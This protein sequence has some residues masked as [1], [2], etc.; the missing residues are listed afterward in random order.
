MHQTNGASLYCLDAAEGGRVWRHSISGD[1]VHVEGS[2]TLID[3]KA[4]VGGGHAGVL[5]F[6]I[7]RATLNDKE[8]GLPELQKLN[9]ATLKELQA[10]YEIER[11]TDAFAFPP[12]EDQLPQAEPKLLW[13]QGK[14]RWHVDAPINVVGDRALVCSAF[15]D[16][17]GV[18]DRALFCL[19]ARTGDLVWRVPLKINPWGG[20]SV[21]G[22]TIIVSGSPIGYDHDA[23]KGA[24]GSIAAYD[25]K[26]GELK[27]HKDI[28]GGV[29]ACA[30]LASSSAVVTST[31]GKVRAFDM[32]TGERQWM[33]DAKHPLFAPAA[34]ARDVVY[35]GDLAGV[36]HAI[37]LNGGAGLWK[38]DLG[39]HPKVQAPGMI[40]AG[41]V[42]FGGRLYA[43][44][45]NLQGPAAGEKTVVVCVGE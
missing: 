11:K 45:C 14:D 44:T 37:D 19:D 42:V 1:L 38:L 43:A 12:S 27:W 22:A 32:A 40:Y 2:P 5:C 36:I 20:P 8:Y 3:G 16:K 25:L 33:Y 15:L 10:K 39:A 28:P 9:A 35:A 4:Y 29:V 21:L 41:P 18:G 26:K 24:K 6:E 31:D 34:I 13:Q 23:I 7:E 17:E 30:A